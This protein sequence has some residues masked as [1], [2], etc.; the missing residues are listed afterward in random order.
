MDDT[1]CLAKQAR[2]KEAFTGCKSRD[3]R[4]EKIISLGRA[5][6]PL[7]SDHKLPENLVQ[8]CQSQMY[9]Y[10][11]MK[12]GLVHFE[13]ESD[14]LISNGLAALLLAVYSEEPAEVILRCAPDYL[15]ELGIAASLTPNR[16][17]GLYSLH[18]RMK[19]AALQFL[20][21]G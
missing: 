1:S 13:A 18:L 10:A 19:Q 17:N 4:Y 2:I 16:A 5:L 11:I 8:G 20:V 12:D 15:E 14:A 21:Q 7:S 3:E 6:K 9:L